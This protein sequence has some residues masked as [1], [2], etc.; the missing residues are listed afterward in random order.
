MSAITEESARTTPPQPTGKAKRRTR[1]EKEAK[2]F[3]ASQWQLMW[4]RFRR[5]QM[6]MISAIVVILIYL[7]ALFAE[8]LA[9][10]NPE[11][12]N[13]RYLYGNSVPHLAFHRA[14]SER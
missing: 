1:E 14:D 10:F 13:A 6:A 9:P 7:V 11:I 12:P 4:W 3:V 5:H 8:F 2:V